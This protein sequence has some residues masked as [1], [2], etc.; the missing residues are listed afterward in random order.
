MSPGWTDNLLQNDERHIGVST[1]RCGISAEIAAI[2]ACLVSN[3]ATYIMGQSIKID[4]GLMR[5]I[6][7]DCNA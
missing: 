1:R 4:D 5:R 6:E 7:N 3:G 2:I